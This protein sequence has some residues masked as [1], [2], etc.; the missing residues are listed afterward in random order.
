MIRISGSEHVSGFRRPEVF[1]AGVMTE[2]WP[3]V[4]GLSIHP[5]EDIVV[6]DTRITVSLA[7]AGLNI[8]LDG[9]VTEYQMN[10]LVRIE[11][12][13]S[14]ASVNVSLD[15][16]DT[17][18]GTDIDYEAIVEPRKLFVRL[19]EPAIREFLRGSVPRFAQGYRANVQDYLI[20]AR[21]GLHH[22]SA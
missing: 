20:E 2:N 11:G 17:R 1:R 4:N 9:K 8:V 6:P 18:E 19:A 15:L 5:H 21:D 3:E 16:S 12:R 14:L 22:H 13:S 10:E 7:A